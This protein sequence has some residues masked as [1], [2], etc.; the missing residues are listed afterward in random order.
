MIEGREYVCLAFEPSQAIRMSGKQIR[1][2]L[3]GDVAMQLRI[4]RPVNFAHPAGTD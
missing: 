3:E 2:D 1:Q 4:A